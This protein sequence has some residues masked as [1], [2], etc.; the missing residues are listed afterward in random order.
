[1]FNN[2]STLILY[3]VIV[4]SSIL[5]LGKSKYGCLVR[6]VI[7]RYILIRFDICESNSRVKLKTSLILHGRRTSCTR[8]QVSYKA[9]RVAAPSES[10]PNSHTYSVSQIS[11]FKIYNL[12]NILIVSKPF[13]HLCNYLP[14]LLQVLLHFRK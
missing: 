13:P 8:F 10:G 2:P 6:T 5:L 9:S 7:S 4:I 11:S 12:K 3:V 1:M 14:F